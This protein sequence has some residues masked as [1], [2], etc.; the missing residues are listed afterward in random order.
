MQTLVRL[1]GPR[2]FV[3]TSSGDTGR[4]CRFLHTHASKE[5]EVATLSGGHRIGFRRYGVENGSA[6]FYLHGGEGSGIE[7]AIFAP[8][9]SK[10]GVSIIAPDR[11]GI[12]SSWPQPNRSI[13]DHAKDVSDLAKVLGL[14]QYRLIGI[15]SVCS[16]YIAANAVC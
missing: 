1:R 7:G 11:P 13:L 8:P 15:R 12:G 6:V 3:A 14:R 10:L 2:V 16:S 5:S 4:L 9:A